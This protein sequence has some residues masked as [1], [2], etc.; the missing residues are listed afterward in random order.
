MLL[1]FIVFER[2]IVA[3]LEKVS[4][5]TTLGPIRN[6][7]GGIEGHEMSCVPEPLHLSP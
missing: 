6:S 7:Q 5:I 2:G 4:A 1:G 3:N